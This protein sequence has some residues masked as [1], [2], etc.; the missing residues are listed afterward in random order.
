ML[1][2]NSLLGTM[3][4]AV[5][6]AGATI[7]S[8]WAQTPAY[9]DHR[10]GSY[11]KI[12]GDTIFY[13]KSGHG[14]AMLLIHGFPLS[15]ELF[16]GQYAALTG[17]YTV[18]VPDLPG[19]GRSTTSTESQT[20]ARYASDLFGLLDHLGVQKA[21]IGGHS[22]GGQVT[23]E[24]YHEQPSRFAGM[25][26]FDTNPAAASLVEK[27][28]FPGFGNQAEAMGSAS[29]A[30]AIV[31]VMVTGT[32]IVAKPELGTEIAGIVSE[33]MPAGVAGGGN[34]LATRANYKP[35]LK[36]IQVPT[37][38]MVGRDDP[39][40]PAPISVA[41]AQAISGSTLAIIPAAAHASM[42]QRPA[43]ANQAIRNWLGKSGLGG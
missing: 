37:L 33:A 13:Q 24:M 36:D 41:L 6:V 16:E 32:S 8:A 3:M 1:F 31:G 21:I 14:P 10:Q 43:L 28:E 15:G 18:I 42:F 7:S 2:R 39:V 40:Y 9:H 17:S 20:E 19:F 30:P 38:V 23:L 11:F 4:S 34:A 26:L 5:V 35:F 29:I 27:G 22:M 12:N 25:I